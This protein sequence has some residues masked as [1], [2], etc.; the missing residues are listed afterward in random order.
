M[1]GWAYLYFKKDEDNYYYIYKWRD[2]RRKDLQTG[3]Y[4]DSWSKIKGIVN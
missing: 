2:Q 1:N 3:D 4:F